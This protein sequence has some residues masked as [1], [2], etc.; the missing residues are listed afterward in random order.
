M[1]LTYAGLI[2][3][4][5]KSMLSNDVDSLQPHIRGFVERAMTF[6][7]CAVCGGTRLN[8]AARSSKIKGINIAEA[9]TMQISDLAEWVGGLD[10]PSV[11][12]LL[13]ALG[14]TLE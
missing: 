1:N 11:A 9:C 2:P 4:I 5:Q 14:E 10:E 7:A 12:P 13:T 3:T 8:E 6:T